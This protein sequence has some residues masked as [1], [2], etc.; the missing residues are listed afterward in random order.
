M[1]ELELLLPEIQ[2]SG[3]LATMQLPEE[4]TYNFWKF[5]NNRILTLDG[6]I[7]DWDYNIVKNIINL[8]MNNN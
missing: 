6:E 3:N 7:S 2:T 4:E 1:K 8:N 5:Y